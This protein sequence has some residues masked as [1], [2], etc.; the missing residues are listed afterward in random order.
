MRQIN[1]H[2][3]Y[4]LALDFN[5]ATKLS[6][7][8]A[9]GDLFVVVMNAREALGR[10]LG[11]ELL[12]LRVCKHAAQD[13]LTELD[14]IWFGYI[15]DRETDKFR[16]FDWKE[17]K[18]P[19]W[20]IHSVSVAAERF[21]H[22]LA[23]EVRGASTYVAPKVGIY[24]TSDLADHAERHIPDDL[25]VHVNARALEDYAAA[26]RCLVFNLPNAAG[27]HVL[28]AVEGVL[29][30]YYK[31]LLGSAAK[32]PKGWHDYITALKAVAKSGQM[33]APEEKTLR[34]LDQL[35]DLDRNP[36]MHPRDWLTL[37]E[38]RELFNNATSAIT[39]M[40]RELGALAGQGHLRL[41]SGGGEAS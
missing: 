34:N 39:A 29:D 6:G 32:E 28:R 3:F 33:P 21:E 24:D 36:V 31:A 13:A 11:G 23:E 16:N 15:F 35:R 10:L 14:R 26:G 8:L 4:R 18:V 37:S 38:A 7:E 17:T 12:D 9:V 1:V 27:F 25:R 22:V 41:V 30:D 40:A 20:L 19:S 5:P 2:D